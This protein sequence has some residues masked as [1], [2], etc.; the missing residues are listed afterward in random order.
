MT[1]LE[2][3]GVYVE[4]DEALALLDGAGARI[5]KAT[6][7]VLIPSSVVE[8][9][10]ETAPG[11]IR[12]YDRFGKVAM[13]LGEDRVHFN[14][15]SA[16][17]R[18]YDFAE[19]RA[20]TPITADVVAFATLTD[21]L[22]NYAAQSTGVIPGDVPEMLADRYRLYL[23][24]LFS[25]KPIVTGT[26]EK[27]AFKVMHEM[28]SAV[29]GDADRLREQPLAIFDCCPSPPLIWSDLT[30]QALI[31]CAR[32]G[33]PAELVSMPLTGAT[34]PV[35]LAGAVTQHCAE[36]LSGIAIHQLA[37]PGSPIVYGGSPACFD[38]RKGTTP[39]RSA[40]TWVC[41][42]TPIWG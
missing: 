33:L 27:Q 38:M 41:L 11:R 35:T 16:A 14:P 34:A 31:D 4:N 9:A 7:R 40:S 6:G 30:A 21:A 23:G 8:K 29:A 10:L 3:V 1:I 20:R 26:F 42:P 5:D 28:L 19:Q 18:V 22:P 32:T 2:E 17:L 39:M 13:D 12:V 37:N 36:N 25:A 15:G 24:L